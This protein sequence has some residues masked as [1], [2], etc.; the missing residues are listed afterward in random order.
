MGQKLEEGEVEVPVNYIYQEISLS[1]R[2]LSHLLLGCRRQCR[3]TYTFYPP[4]SPPLIFHPDPHF[5]P[6]VYLLPFFSPLPPSL[7]LFSLVLS[8]CLRNSLLTFSFCPF[9]SLPPFPSLL[10]PTIFHIS[11]CKSLLQGVCVLMPCVAQ[12]YEEWTRFKC[13]LKANSLS[14]GRKFGFAIGFPDSSA[15]T[16]PMPG[17]FSA[18]NKNPLS[19]SFSCLTDMGHGANHPHNKTDLCL[20]VS[21]YIHA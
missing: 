16:K 11:L 7:F 19:L 9:F 20:L 12:G 15:L 2:L 6:S 5:P 18:S 14:Y 4:F 8:F 17:L 1:V 10:S 13:A 21:I 3:P